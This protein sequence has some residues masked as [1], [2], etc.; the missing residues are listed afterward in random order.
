MAQDEWVLRLLSLHEQSARLPISHALSSHMQLGKFSS[1]YEML[2]CIRNTCLSTV[3]TTLSLTRY[4][5]VTTLWPHT[6][7]QNLYPKK[8]TVLIK[9]LDK[10]W[11]RKDQ[12]Q[13]YL[14]QQKALGTD[15]H[16][17]LPPN[18]FLL[19]EPNILTEKWSKQG[20]S[21]TGP[22][23][24]TSVFVQCQ[25]LSHKMGDPFRD[26]QRP[27]LLNRLWSTKEKWILKPVFSFHTFNTKQSN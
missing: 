8:H 17:C 14:L 9:H 15:L 4:I 7:H 12:Y 26:I 20:H 21:T 27:V 1:I 16:N 23:Q 10:T 13:G 19:P 2:S 6:L 22:Q 3:R 24:T 18:D 25:R 11:T 5:T